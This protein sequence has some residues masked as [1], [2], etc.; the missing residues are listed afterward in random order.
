MRLTLRGHPHRNRRGTNMDRN[1]RRCWHEFASLRR[2]RS[3]SRQ[4]ISSRLSMG[5]VADAG[6]D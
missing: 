6:G 1:N 3:N 5:L 4:R 2:L